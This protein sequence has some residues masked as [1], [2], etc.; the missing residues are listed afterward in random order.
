MFD[1][2]RAD[3]LDSFVDST[4]HF[5]RCVRGEEREPKLTGARGREVLRVESEMLRVLRTRRVT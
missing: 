1:D 3:W 5:I 4:R 2:L